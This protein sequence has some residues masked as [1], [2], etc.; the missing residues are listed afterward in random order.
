MFFLLLFD[1]ASLFVL[2]S[3]LKNRVNFEERRNFSNSISKQKQASKL[4][5][6]HALRF[7]VFMLPISQEEKTS[8]SKNKL[9][10][11]QIMKNHDLVSTFA[12]LRVVSFAFNADIR[13]L[14]SL[15]SDSHGECSMIGSYRSDSADSVCPPRVRA[16]LA[17]RACRSSVMIGDSLGRTE[18][19]KV[20]KKQ[21]H[22]QSRNHLMFNLGII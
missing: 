14:I 3:G 6:C 16:M 19:Q 9:T 2:V 22:V 20:F 10:I 13:D 15:L 4:Q 12:V 5:F 7:A 18:M 21:S 11:D 17:S 1:L 8:E